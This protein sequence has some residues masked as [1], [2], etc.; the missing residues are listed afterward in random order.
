MVT[1]NKDNTY[2]GFLGNRMFQA[3]S[4]IGISIDNKMEYGF[5]RNEYFSNFKNFII[6][7]EIST[8]SFITRDEAGFGFEKVT[9]DPSKNY[10]IMGYRQS[11]KYFDH[12]KE[13]IKET[14]VFNDQIVEKCNSIIHNLKTEFASKQLVSVHIR[15]G[16]YLDL[17]NH[18]TCLMDIGYYQKAIEEFDQN[19]TVF[20]L[21]SDNIHIASTFFSKLNRSF[22]TLDSTFPGMDLCL[23]SKCDGHIIANSSFSWWASYLSGKKTISPS[24]NNWFGPAY[25]DMN[26]NDIIPNEWKQ[27]ELR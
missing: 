13:L 15:C 22:K 20:I 27:I 9:L 21:F 4:T 25:K 1:H 24:K 2:T 19:N 3:A 18:H 11:Y 23:M 17:K 14:F 10:N 12:C 6:K 5:V 8:T 16:D 7:P 26:T